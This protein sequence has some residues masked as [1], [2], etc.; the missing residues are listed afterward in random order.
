MGDHGCTR[1]IDKETEAL[2]GEVTC[3]W[4]C[5]QAVEQPALKPA[6]SAL[7]VSPHS[8][9]ILLDYFLNYLFIYLAVLGF[10]CGTQDLYCGVWDLFFFF[11]L[12]AACRLL[13]GACGI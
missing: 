5:S 4:S 13:V 10:S 12:F 1:F 8:I 11:F 7:G 6:S 3:P 9:F 2:G